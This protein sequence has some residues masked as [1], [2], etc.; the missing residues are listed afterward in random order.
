MG[1]TTGRFSMFVD[2]TSN[3]QACQQGIN[4]IQP[5]MLAHQSAAL[6]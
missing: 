3:F 6:R 4:K 1:S 5:S 2:A